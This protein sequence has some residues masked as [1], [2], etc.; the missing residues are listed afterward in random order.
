MNIEEKVHGMNN[1]TEQ[2]IKGTTE[3]I[4]V[5]EAVELTELSDDHTI[6]LISSAHALRKKF[7]K[8]FF[9]NHVIH[10][11]HNQGD[12]N[13]HDSTTTST[14]RQMKQNGS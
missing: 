5:K 14:S 8:L 2:L 10:N 11:Y 6:D 12:S 1:I 4:S 9:F 7:K 3:A 13:T